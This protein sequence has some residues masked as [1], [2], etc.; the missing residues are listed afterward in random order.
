MPHTALYPLI[1]LP[2]DNHFQLKISGREQKN[3]SMGLTSLQS[4]SPAYQLS[5][6]GQVNYN[7]LSGF[8]HL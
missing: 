2:R 7:L 8:P 3:T 1:L 5:D 4:I 6:L